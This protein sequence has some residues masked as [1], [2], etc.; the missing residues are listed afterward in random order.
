MTN[1]EVRCGSCIR[2]DMG[3]TGEAPEL[4]ILDWY[5]VKGEHGWQARRACAHVKLDVQFCPNCERETVC[6]ILLE[7]AEHVE[8]DCLT[9]GMDSERYFPRAETQP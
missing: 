8:Y 6:H 2:M 3:G 5:V 1:I 9:C 4:D 7:D